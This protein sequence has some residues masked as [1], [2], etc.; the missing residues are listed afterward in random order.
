MHKAIL[1]ALCIP[2]VYNVIPPY[3]PYPVYDGPSCTFC[4]QYYYNGINELIRHSNNN[5]CVVQELLKLVN[6]I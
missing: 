5:A 4:F 3:H 1:M 2:I 6:M